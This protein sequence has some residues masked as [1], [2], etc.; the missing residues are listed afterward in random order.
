MSV[1]LPGFKAWL[2]RA[3]ILQ[4]V[5]KIKL[6]RGRITLPVRP[7]LW[8]PGPRNLHLNGFNAAMGLLI[9]GILTFGRGDE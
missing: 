5:G 2:R 6:T 8:Q 7:S 9:S 1:S 3:K 4:Y